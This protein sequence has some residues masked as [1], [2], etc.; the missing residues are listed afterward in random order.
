MHYRFLCLYIFLCTTSTVHAQTDT[1]R[2]YYPD[3]KI[4]SVVPMYKG[5]R[6]GEAKIYNREGF[7]IEE[8]NYVNGRVEGLVKKYSDKG[9]L[10][11]LFNVEDG[12]RQGPTSLF[13]STGTYVRDVEFASGK[14]VIIQ[15]EK[16]EEITISKPITAVSPTNLEQTKK[17]VIKS[18][19]KN[20]NN[21][22]PAK[23]EA[24]GYDDDPAYFISVD[25]EP[26]PV[27][28]Y[29]EINRRVYYPPLAKKKKIKGI[30]KIKAYID[31][32][33]DVEK[34]EIVEGIGHGCDEAAEITVYYTKFTPG[35]FKG[36]P[37]KVQMIVPVEF[38][39]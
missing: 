27:D 7:L 25:V 39:F 4:E 36:K 23:E 37:V 17:P 9:I 33:G 21:A 38:K 30:V 8:R 31:R 28:G 10:L 32:N 26:K 1:V 15:E 22:L 3:Y 18:S 11:E 12:K 35:L 16:E 2:N 19:N 6:E 24:E 13:D 14:L 20:A 29:E 5:V 34:T